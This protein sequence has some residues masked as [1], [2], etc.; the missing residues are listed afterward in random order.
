MRFLVKAL[1]TRQ[2][3]DWLGTAAFAGIALTLFR[4]APEFG[5]LI[6]PAL[7]Q[8]ILIAISFLVRGR[9]RAV[10]PG[11]APRAV[12]YGNTFV[13][14]GF[15]WLATAYS[16]EWIRPTPQED[17]APGH[18]TVALRRG[19]GALAA[20]ALATLLQH[21]A[22]GADPGDLRPTGSQGIRCTRCIC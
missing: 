14:M 6:L 16:R 7:L 20:V 19:A 10:A 8:E 11:W 13:V 15:I 18:V 12:A 9:S 1:T 17:Q 3:S 4:R 22:G 2:W 21:R 5:L